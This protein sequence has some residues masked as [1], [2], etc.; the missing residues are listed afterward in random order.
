[1][2]KQSLI[3]LTFWVSLLS[4]NANSITLSPNSNGGGDIP[5]GHAE[6]QFN[7]Y[8]GNF[9]RT[10]T[11]PKTALN[12]AK[13]TINSNAT[14]P[15]TINLRH[16]D[17]YLFISSA[18][19]TKGRSISF[20]FNT[21]INKW[22]VGQ[23]YSMDPQ[24]ANLPTP[25]D[26]ITHW[27]LAD[28]QFAPSLKLPATASNNAIII[29]SSDATLD[30]T[31]ESDN[32]LFGTPLTLSASDSYA[33][34]FSTRINKW[35]REGSSIFKTT[36]R[37]VNITVNPKK[38]VTNVSFYNGNW[39]NKIRLPENAGDRFRVNIKSTATY[40]TTI[41][42]DNITYSGTLT[43]KY[44]DTYQFTFI[45]EKSSWV[46][47]QSPTRFYQ[48]KDI[49]S[50]QIPSMSSPHSQLYSSNANWRSTITL[51]N[52]AKFGD[53]VTIKSAAEHGFDLVANESTFGVKRINQ[54]DEFQFTFNNNGQ[55]DLTTD[56][57]RI[58]LVSSDEV[59]AKIGKSA[60]RAR[61]FEALS[62]TNEALRNSNTSARFKLAGWLQHEVEGDKLN[63]ALGAVRRDVVVQNYR[64]RIKADS[65]YYEGNENGCGFGYLVGYTNAFNMA[66]AGSLGCGVH[67]MRH[68]LGHNLGINHAGTNGANG[69][70][71]ARGLGLV[72]GG[73]VMGGNSLPYFSS[74]H[75]YTDNYGQSFGIINDIDAARA[76]SEHSFSAS[77]LR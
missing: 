28:A 77:Q 24:H 13:I 30:S 40:N 53:K 32:T 7:L 41:L 36:A 61:V 42:N 62:L 54:D 57:I 59:V 23:Q 71:Y 31:I 74:P 46:V 56:Q 15:A 70:I 18:T 43:L 65:V 58:L 37:Q 51:P 16:T 5:G 34:K 64:D 39:R 50:G 38:P 75:Q 76:I 33:F 1:M 69:L 66:A 27:Q 9:S 72:T 55:W 48:V 12:N 68:E 2:K 19:L 3:F 35:L 22:E 73:T 14:I 44:G 60:A 45:K 10:L 29:I 8:N 25:V 21:N 63:E 67:V 4:F 11:L 6:I 49:A 47:T 20:I 52:R 17:A 26:L